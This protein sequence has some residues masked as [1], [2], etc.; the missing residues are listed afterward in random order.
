MK[1]AIIYFFSFLFLGLFLGCEE[2]YEVANLEEFDIEEV[3]NPFEQQF[4]AGSDLSYLNEMIDCGASYN[5]LAGSNANPF[6]IFKNAGNDL[7][8]VRLWNDPS[9]WTAYSNIEDVE[10]T[11]SSSKEQ[12]M[13][14]LLDFHY[15]DTWADP[16]NQIIP[17]AWLDVVDNTEALSQRLYDYTYETL[18]NLAEKDL[19]PE[20]VQ[21]GNEINGNILNRES[22]WFE[23]DWERNAFLI[24]Q[25]IQAVRDI[26]KKHG[27]RV[28]IMLHIAQPENALWWF[29]QAKENGVVNYDWIGVSYYPVWSEY[30]VADISDAVSALG[31]TYNK[32]VMIVETAYPFTTENADA[33]NNILGKSVYPAN[34]Q[35]QLDFLLDLKREIKEGNG[36][37][38]VYWEPA[39]VSTACS[40]LFGEGSHWDNAT[41][42]DNSG[43]PTLGMNIFNDNFDPEYHCESIWALGDG[44]PDALWNWDNAIEVSCDANK[45]VVALNLAENKFRFFQTEGDWTS[46]IGYQ[47]FVNRGY[48][49]DSKLKDAN[50]NDDNFVFEGTPGL[51][52]LEIDGEGKTIQLN[53]VISE[54]YYA[55]GDAL[56]GG[57]SFDDATLVESPI[58]GIR[59]ATVNLSPGTFRFF[60][61]KDDWAS[62]LNYAY[63]ADQGYTID[64]NLENAGDGDQNF[65]FVGNTGEYVLE[66]NDNDKTITLL[67]S[68]PFPSIWAVGDAVPGGWGFN[69]DTIEFT[70]TFSG[71]WT[72]NLELNA[73]VFRFF[74]TFGTWDTNNNYAYYAGEGFEI[75]ANLENDGSGDENFR[76]IGV[77]GAYTLTINAN[78]K[79]ITLEE[80]ETL[81]SLWAVG[82]AVPGGWGFNDDTVEFIQVTENVW[83]AEIALNNGGI[84]RFFQIYGTWDT[85]NNYEF[86][87]GEGYTIDSNFS[88]QDA[89]DKNFL[90]TGSSG[91][92]VLTINGNDKTI[93]LE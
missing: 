18:D 30:E 50:D 78:S 2:T 10:K 88:E 25:G 13:D 39:W 4:Y 80:Y 51:Y 44:V 68:G 69:D 86:Y 76:F 62:G 8:R 46:G 27:A 42:F 49:I 79:R 63:F 43:N 52:T 75:D 3:R 72:A 64:S 74:Q 7:V 36:F 73:G 61:Q 66:I 16:G 47:Y 22:G 20:I 33:A 70:Q 59:R 31:S 11:I 34:Q 29:E 9:E 24:N 12:G 21:L 82:D 41:L 55:L 23:I 60:T 87:A 57:W 58:F 32:K 14:I 89:A 85:N 93:T 71:V 48:T 17:A 77:P 15:S 83:T 19:L 5:G 90:F 56:P 26:S 40:T 28:Q 84:F 35:G 6:E 1:K 65:R 67:G 45:N 92:Y 53:P 54:T 38:L 37:G 91:S 81:P